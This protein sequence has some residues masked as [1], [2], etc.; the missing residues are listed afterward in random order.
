MV[1]CLWSILASSEQKWQCASVHTF[2]TLKLASHPCFP[3][4]MGWASF[5]LVWTLCQDLFIWGL[6]GLTLT[7]MAKVCWGCGPKWTELSTSG[8]PGDH[9]G[10]SALS[11]QCFACGVGDGNE[12]LTRG[13]LSRERVSSG[14]W[15][16]S[17]RQRRLE[18]GG[19]MGPGRW[20]QHACFRFSS[21]GSTLYCFFTSQPRFFRP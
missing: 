3:N 17:L 6:G 9:Q 15:A 5:V 12:Q 16:R 19:W 8:I 14:F 21:L 18:A 13:P 10:W 4:K 2:S 20:R 7:D 1:Q 11:R